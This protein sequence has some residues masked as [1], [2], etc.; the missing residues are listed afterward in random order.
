MDWQTVAAAAIVAVTL[1]TFVIR[2]FRPGRKSGC[3]KGCCGKK[4]S[5]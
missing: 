1:A 4:Q 3:A 2:F 5:P